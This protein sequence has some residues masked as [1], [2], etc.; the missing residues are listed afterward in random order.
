ML[1]R[2]GEG[3]GEHTDV[4]S[5]LSDHQDESARETLLTDSVYSAEELKP[6]VYGEAQCQW[7][8]FAV[9]CDHYFTGNVD[10]LR[11]DASFERIIPA[12]G[13]TGAPRRIKKQINHVIQR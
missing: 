12:S 13:A 6:W 3:E 7:L 9:H 8:P 4:F 2:E 10:I 11:T 5:G 1:Q